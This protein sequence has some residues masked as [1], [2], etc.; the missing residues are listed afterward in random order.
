MSKSKDIFDEYMYKKR[1]I[2]EEVIDKEKKEFEEK[3][4]SKRYEIDSMISRSSFGGLYQGLLNE[5]EQLDSELAG[6]VNKTRHTIDVELYNM[7]KK[8]ENKARLVN[9]KINKRINNLKFI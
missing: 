5:K 8:V 2:R 4:K 7:N 3:L 1:L 6:N 9:Y